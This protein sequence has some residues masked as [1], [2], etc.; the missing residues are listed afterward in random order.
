MSKTV[1]DFFVDRLYEWR[2]CRI[3]GCP[4][5]GIDGIDGIDGVLG[6]LQRTSA[7]SSSSR[8]ARR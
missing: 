5:D 8:C 3:F 4:G 2:V 6:A 1:G 7:R